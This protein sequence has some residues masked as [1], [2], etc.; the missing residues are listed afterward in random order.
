MLKEAILTLEG[1]EKIKEELK[2]LETTRRSAVIERLQVARSLGDLSENS[3]YDDARNEQS[4]VEG[5]IHELK[6]MIKHAKIVT[7]KSIHGST[8]DLGS[9]VTCVLEG[10][11]ETYEIVSSA[12]ADPVQGKISI[13]SPLGSALIGKK[14]GDDALVH[15]P[16][17]SLTYSIHAV[18]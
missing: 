5:R 13:D 15:A 14:K 18:E 7:K 10:E 12:E 9:R 8:A 11:S 4:F 1:L 16:G 2:E 17:G 3:E 6:E